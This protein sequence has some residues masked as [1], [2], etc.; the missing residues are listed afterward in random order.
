[1]N[2]HSLL[3]CRKKI[4]VLSVDAFVQTSHFHATEQ[5][6]EVFHVIQKE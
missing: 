5:S 3:H 2:F 6:S 4:S 1:M